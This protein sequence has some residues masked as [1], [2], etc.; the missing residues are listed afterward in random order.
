MH[1]LVIVRVV[2]VP[3]AL[4]RAEKGVYCPAFGVLLHFFYIRYHRF[5][6]YPNPQWSGIQHRQRR[7]RTENMPV[8]RIKISFV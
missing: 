2:D 4:T 7:Q 5:Y 3:E 1:K 6:G 8:P